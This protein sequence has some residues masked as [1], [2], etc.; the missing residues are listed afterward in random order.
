MGDHS[1]I[2]NLQCDIGNKKERINI[3]PFNILTLLFYELEQGR[4]EF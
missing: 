3:L 1:V 4:K 2:M